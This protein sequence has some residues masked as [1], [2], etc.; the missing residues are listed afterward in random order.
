VVED[1]FERVVIDG[2]GTDLGSVGDFA[3]VEGFSVFEDE[4]SLRV[5]G[6]KSG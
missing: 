6:G 5:L 4:E 1:E 3:G 2:T